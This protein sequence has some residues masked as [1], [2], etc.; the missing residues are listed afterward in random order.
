MKNIFQCKK[1][2]VK[3][4]KLNLLKKQILVQY[5]IDQ[6]TKKKFWC[7]FGL[8]NIINFLLKLQNGQLINK[9]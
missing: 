6:N 1:T 8:K 7:F 3:Q 4:H 9:H 2:C 5:F